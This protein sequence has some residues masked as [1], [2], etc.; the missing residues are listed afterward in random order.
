MPNFKV[1]IYEVILANAM[2][3][4]CFWVYYKACAVGPGEVNKENVK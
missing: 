1:S 2:A 4:S 3:L